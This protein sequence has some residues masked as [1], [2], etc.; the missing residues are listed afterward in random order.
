M[1]NNTIEFNE[2]KHSTRINLDELKHLYSML[3]AKDR[4][5]KQLE[6]ENAQ[7]KKKMNLISITQGVEN[8]R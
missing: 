2:V 8:Y 5:I 6:A 3:C 7:L 1:L 4:K